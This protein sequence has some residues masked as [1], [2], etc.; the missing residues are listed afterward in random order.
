MSNSANS[1]VCRS[2]SRLWNR[3]DGEPS[4]STGTIAAAG[5]DVLEDLFA[6]VMNANAILARVEELGKELLDAYALWDE[7][8]SRS[9]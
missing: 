8:D 2:A 6:R 9:K 7:L 4:A 1:I 3:S 5:F